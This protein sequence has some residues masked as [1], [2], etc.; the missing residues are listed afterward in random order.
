MAKI[1][2]ITH[3]GENA[4]KSEPPHTAGQNVKR[5]Q[6]SH[7]G[8]QSGTFQRVNIELP[9]KPGIPTLG[10]YLE[11]MTMCPYKTLYVNV[12]SSIIF[13][14]QKVETIRGPS[15]EEQINK[16]WYVHTMESYSPIQRN[17]VL[18]YITTEMSL[19][20]HMKEDTNSHILYDSDSKKTLPGT[21]LLCL[22]RCLCPSPISLTAT[23]VLEV[24][25]AEVD[26]T[27]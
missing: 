21:A 14:S 20:C 23:P 7:F 2:Q 10:N 27:G 22:L 15:A 25:V 19:K 3:N 6:N 17:E 24:A 8:K 16:M 12:R 4:E 13:N 1:R 18:I 5:F 26:T 9:S 11:E